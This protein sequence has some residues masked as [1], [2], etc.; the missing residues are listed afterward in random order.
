MNKISKRSLF[1][2]VGIVLVFILCI[3]FL[4]LPKSSPDKVVSEISLVLP[5]Y[6]ESDITND[7]QLIVEG[8]VLQNLDSKYEESKNPVTND[9]ETVITTDTL[10][11]VTNVLKGELKDK[12][13]TIRSDEGEIKDKI[14]LCQDY[15]DFEENE[16]VLLFLNADEFEN[17]ISCWRLSHLAYSKFLLKEEGT[18]YNTYSETTIDIENIK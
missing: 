7:S 13:I 6:K 10:I 18:Y 16:K 14:V 2:V 4:L 9:T 1:L 12:E 11:S 8:V 15:P 3:L 17:D 5:P